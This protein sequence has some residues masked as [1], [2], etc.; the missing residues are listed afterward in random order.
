MAELS[1]ESVAASNPVE[2]QFEDIKDRLHRA[3]IGV[4]EGRRIE[5]PKWDDVLFLIDQMEGWRRLADS[6]A[7]ECDRLRGE[8]IDGTGCT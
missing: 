7:R 3:R 8:R 6:W 5:S 1:A 4:L 2:E